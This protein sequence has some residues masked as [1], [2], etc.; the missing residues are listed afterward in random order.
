MQSFPWKDIFKLGASTAASKFCGWNQGETDILMSDL[1]TVV[2][3]WI[4]RAFN[5][6]WQA[7][8]LHK[9]NSYGILGSSFPSNR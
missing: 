1:R 4:A 7:G 9:L 8:L 6:Y 3:D 5:R 2:S